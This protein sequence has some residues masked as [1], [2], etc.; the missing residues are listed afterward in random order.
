[1]TEE[2]ILRRKSQLFLNNLSPVK[3]TYEDFVR[4]KLKPGKFLTTKTGVLKL[5]AMLSLLFS[6]AFFVAQKRC[7]D[8]SSWYPYLL[9]ISLGVALI[10]QFVLYCIF[11]VGGAVKQPGFWIY[12]DITV[13]LLCSVCSLITSIL[14]YADCASTS[15]LHKVPGITGMLGGIALLISC[16]TIFMM[17][18]YNEELD[19][20]DQNS[21]N[22]R[23]KRVV[24]SR[25]SIFA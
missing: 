16:G 10:L 7:E 21:S 22:I 24:D 8:T 3:N 5:A 23:N 14:T 20:E 12:M 13:I 6:V 15:V 9:P 19:N 25:K 17:Y 11:S 18:R 4:K 2:A 1:M